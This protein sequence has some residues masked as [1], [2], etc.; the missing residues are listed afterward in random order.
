MRRSS[1]RPAERARDRGRRARPTVRLKPDTTDVTRA[2][3]L[4]V[5]SALRRTSAK[6]DI[7]GLLIAACALPALTVLTAP[8]AAAQSPPQPNERVTFTN[9]IAPIVW[10]RCSPCHRPGEVGPFSL[11]T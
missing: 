2:R 8:L 4:D 6:P 11:L 7:A 10:S 9:D 3:H 1:N 5:E